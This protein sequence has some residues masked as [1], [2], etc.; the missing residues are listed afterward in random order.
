MP[1][2][3]LCHSPSDEGRFLFRPNALSSAQSGIGFSRF[4]LEHIVESCSSFWQYGQT[5]GNLS[6]SKSPTLLI[7]TLPQ[8]ANHHANA[9]GKND[10]GETP[11][12]L[13][14]LARRLSPPTTSTRCVKIEEG[15]RW[16]LRSAKM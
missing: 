10:S 7:P 11:A 3:I 13:F 14:E 2:N 6:Q 9:F 4:F 12:F 15:S 1:R 8:S 16:K 5:R